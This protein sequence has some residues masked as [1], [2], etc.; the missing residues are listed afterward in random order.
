MIMMIIIII[1]MIIIIAIIIIS[2]IIIIIIIIILI[3]IIITIIMILI[4]IIIYIYIYIY[5]HIIMIIIIIIIMMIMITIAPPAA[6]GDRGGRDR[7]KVLHCLY[8]ECTTPSSQSKIRVFSDPTLGK[9]SRRRQI[10]INKKVSGQ[11]S[12]W[13]KSWIVN[14]CYANWV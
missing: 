7:G 4:I 10:P 6:A 11:P 8:E 14:S 13:S 3:I 1:M 9:S 5:M 2:I 12:P